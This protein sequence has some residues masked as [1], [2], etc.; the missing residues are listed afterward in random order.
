MKKSKRHSTAGIYI[1]L[2]IG[3]V[4]MIFPFIWMILTAFKTN[5]EVPQIPPTI[6]PSHW[7]LDSFK[8]AIDLL[9]FG[10][11]YINTALMILFRVLCAVAFC[12]MAGYAFAKLNFKGK[13]ILFTLII[14]QQ[15]IPGQIFIR[16]ISE[17][18]R[19]GR[20]DRYAVFPCIS[21]YRQRVRNILPQTGVYGYTGRN[22]GSGLS[23]RL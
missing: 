12:S 6:L 19:Q 13:N 21:R 5:A 2:G 22:R 1:A 7:N 15:M 11:L 4:I 9:P 8:N 3:S 18:A 16:A 10:N 17:Y 23:G 20:T 14:V